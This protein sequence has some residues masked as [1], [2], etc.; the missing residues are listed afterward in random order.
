MKNLIKKEGAFTLIE[1]LVVILIIAILIAVSAPS[2]LGQTQKAQ[3][4]AANQY[5][6]IAYRTVKAW[7]VGDNGDG[8]PVDGQNTFSGFTAASDLY[9]NEPELS[10]KTVVSGTPTDN[11]ITF[12]SVSSG[13]RNCVQTFLADSGPVG[14]GVCS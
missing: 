6:A 13:A 10:G 12:S 9:P 8:T 5:N 14:S 3:D 2:F 4:S 7:A 1:L 11:S